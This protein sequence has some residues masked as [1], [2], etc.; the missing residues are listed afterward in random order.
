MLMSKS[1]RWDGWIASTSVRLSPS[2]I[3]LWPTLHPQP[4]P[5]TWRMDGWMDGCVACSGQYVLA[6]TPLIGSRSMAPVNNDN[7]SIAK[8]TKITKSIS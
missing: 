1:M 4:S 2:A 3:G 6:T 5:E 8:I 7:E